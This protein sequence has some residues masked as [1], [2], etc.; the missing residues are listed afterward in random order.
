M[1]D[2]SRNG[3]VAVAQTG[4]RTGDPNA[5]EFAG[6]SLWQV[7]FSDAPAGP[8]NNWFTSRN[9]SVFVDQQGRLHLTIDKP[10]N[11]SI[12]YSTEVILRQELGYGYYL[13][14][15]EGVVNELDLFA[16]FG[17]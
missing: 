6:R 17:G 15:V 1:L 13:F 11:S 7:K 9:D 5:L 14:Q 16:T 4:K 12:W 8:G 3:T 10:K 2:G